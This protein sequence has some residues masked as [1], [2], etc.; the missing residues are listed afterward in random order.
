MTLRTGMGLMLGVFALMVLLVGTGGFVALKEAKHSFD[1]LH[2]L[3]VTSI[4]AAEQAYGALMSTR[5]Q[6]NTYQTLYN[7]LKVKPAKAAWEQAEA[8]FSRARQALL[9]LQSSQ[10][11]A[12]EAPLI[13]AAQAAFD[14]LIAQGITPTFDALKRWD[15]DDYAEANTQANLLTDQ[16]DI[17]LAQLSEHAGAVGADATGAITRNVDRMRIGIPALLVLASALMLL[18]YLLAQRAL[19]RPLGQARHHFERIAAGDLT[20]K[21]EA[22]SNNEIGK[23]FMSLAHMQQAL[24]EMVQTMRYNSHGLRDNASACSRQ[25]FAIIAIIDEIAFQTN[26]LALNASVEAARA[27]E[28]GRG[29]AVVANEVRI[30]SRRS[31]EAAASIRQLIEETH[32]RVNQG[33]SGIEAAGKALGE[34]ES[35]SQHVAT[36]LSQIAQVSQEQSDGIEQVS[37]AIAQIEATAQHNA[38]MTQQSALAARDLYHRSGLLDAHVARFTTL[39]E[40]VASAD[41]GDDKSAATPPVSS[42]L[43]QTS[44]LPVAAGATEVSLT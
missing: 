13:E 16:L 15:L 34:A 12:K 8:S 9:Q 40:D 17:A 11:G 20:A 6:L 1:T 22:R 25:A 29:F 26:L 23:L 35:A 5:L 4:G 10:V 28:K 41:E 3:N 32:E 39:P 18:G 7:R 19:F 37:R 21:I 14:A 30:L 24:Q 44:R 31:A 36:L 38:A 27:G 2:R 42:P 43:Q 33:A